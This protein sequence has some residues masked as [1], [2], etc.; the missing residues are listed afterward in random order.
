ML[1]AFKKTSFLTI[2][3]GVL[4][5]LALAALAG[6]NYDQVPPTGGSQGPATGGGAPSAAQIAA[7]TSGGG[8]GGGGSQQGNPPSQKA[9][10]NAV[11]AI[12]HPAPK[13]PVDNSPPIPMGND[14]VMFRVMDNSINAY[15]GKCA[16]PYSR[17]SD[18]FECGVE[19]AYY[20]PGGFRIYC[21]PEDVRG[22]LDIFYRKTH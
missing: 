1:G 4:P 18:G 22:Q 10:T 12:L 8:G 15:H 20:K 17:N 14:E 3:V 21:Y 13:T 7:A 19:A 2:L 16:C 6:V 5:H 11:S 9:N